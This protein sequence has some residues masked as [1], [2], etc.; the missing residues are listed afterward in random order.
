MKNTVPVWPF[1]NA[2]T[3][4]FTPDSDAI[5]PLARKI[6]TAKYAKYT[7]SKQMNSVI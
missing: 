6:Q 2:W 3:D 5:S 7:K 1:A 4:P